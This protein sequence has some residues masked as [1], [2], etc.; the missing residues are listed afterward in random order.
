MCIKQLEE[1][2]AQVENQYTRSVTRQGNV[3]AQELIRRYLG[4]SLEHGEAW[5]VSTKAG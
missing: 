1:G 4:R 2:R 3:A 5:G